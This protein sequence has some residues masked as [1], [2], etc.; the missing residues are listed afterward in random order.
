MGSGNENWDNGKRT[1][2]SNTGMTGK[3]RARIRELNKTCGFENDLFHDEI[4]DAVTRSGISAASI[5]EILDK[6]ERRHA[7]RPL[8]NPT[9]W[10]CNAIVKEGPSRGNDS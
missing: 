10:L 6:L 4:D 5:H 7:E 8:E 9:G 3:I 1:D 2:S